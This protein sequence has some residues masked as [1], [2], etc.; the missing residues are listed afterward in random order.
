MNSINLRTNKYDPNNDANGRELF[1]IAE[2]Q[3][4]FF[5]KKGSMVAYTG[6]F[7]FEKRLLD[8]NDNDSLFKQALNHIERK[9]TH[10][11][12]E[13]MEVTGRGTVYLADKASHITVIDLDN[14]TSLS[15]ESENLLAFTKDC[16]YGV[17]FLPIGTISQKGLFTTTL[18]GISNNAQVAVT[19]IGNPLVITTPCIV[20]PDAIV[21]WTGP[22]PSIKTDIGLKT[23]FGQSSGET[24]S[25]KFDN[26]GY[27]VIIQ[28][29]ERAGNYNRGDNRYR[30]NSSFRIS[31]D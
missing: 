24:Y 26:P 7:K 3:G 4:S 22:A 25:L 11:N 17:K 2:G 30:N 20:D 1:C 10:E 27:F 13:I 9:F 18:T 29:Y 16:Y 8:T 19:T 12:L 28:P 31:M 21:A 5:S 14:N 23:F 15:V 6:D